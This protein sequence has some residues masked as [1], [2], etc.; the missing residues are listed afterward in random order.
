M[1][2]IKLLGLISCI[3]LSYSLLIG[4]TPIDSSLWLIDL[5]DVVVTAQYAPTDSRN[6]LHDIQ[7]I[8]RQHIEARGVNNL[9]QALQQEA[10]LRINQDL[11][12]GSSVQLLGLGGQNIKIMIDGVPVIGRQGGNIDLTQINL[13]NIERVEIVEG[14]LS[15]GY[16]TD[17]LAGVI[18]LITRKSQLKKN[19]LSLTVQDE[20]RGERN[21]QINLGRRFGAHWLLTA[22]AGQ[23]NF[24]GFGF[25]D[26]LR[27]QEWNPKE[28][29]YGEASLRFQKNKH[30]LR[31]QFGVF[32]ENVTNLGE[33]RRPNFKPYAFDDFY[34]T[35]RLDHALNYIGQLG[36]NFHAQS[37]LAYNRFRRYK[38]SYRNDFETGEELLLD[39]QQDTSRF[40]AWQWRSTLASQWKDSPV[41]FQVGLDLRY[42]D[43]TG[44]RIQDSLSGRENFS[45]I[46]DY[47]IFGQL[48]YQPWT[49]LMVE[50]GLRYAYNSRYQA[51]L[52]PSVHLKYELDQHWTVRASYGKGFRSPDLKE[53]FFNFIDINHFIIGN[54]DLEAE[55]SNNFQ[56]SWHYQ[57]EN[58]RGEKVGFKLKGFYNRIQDKITLFEFIDTEEGLR[59]AIDT[60]TFQFAYFNQEIDKN[61]GVNLRFSYQTG[62]L[63]LQTGISMIGYFQP[64]YESLELDPFTYAIELN[65]EVSYTVPR[66]DL[67]FS[68]Y[69]RNNDRLINF[70]PDTND[71]GE[72]IVSQR[73][74]EGFMLT[75]L[76]LGIPLWKKRLQLNGGVRN[77]LDVQTVAVSSGGAAGQ[78]HSTNTG[79]AVVGLGRSF[80]LRLQLDL[81][82]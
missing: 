70:F 43:A 31:Y 15:V 60:S 30:D 67:R 57:H 55:N 11:V 2:I 38:N 28:Q 10:G 71:E 66:S 9:E 69:W 37:V 74:Q 18:N 53:L 13:Q 82:W 17:A 75:D 20:T 68:I 4:Q 29:Q 47:A 65:G 32:D 3:L 72:S 36:E 46:Q 33:V 52:V 21:L 7:T 42:D 48:R 22:S 64:E 45:E 59:P 78:G 56:L 25:V 54:P 79:T 12:L 27:F 41:Q 62:A 1:K 6:A 73:I 49:R 81:N 76:T 14:P 51:P 63:N 40:S 35:Q 19:R 23:D 26:T 61:Q 50:G 58:S 80:F 16:G 44:K 8:K 34:Q 5:E 77:L 39:G 24:E